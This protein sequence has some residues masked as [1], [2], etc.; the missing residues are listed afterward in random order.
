MSIMIPKLS[1]ILGKI[2]GIFAL[3]EKLQVFLPVCSNK[4]WILSPKM[5]S[6]APINRCISV[7][8]KSSG[9]ISVF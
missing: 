5:S 7:G 9:I 1:D 8:S 4:L 2:F 3:D 6:Y